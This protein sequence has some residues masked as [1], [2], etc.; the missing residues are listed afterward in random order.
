M[1]ASCLVVALG[2]LAMAGCAA[3]PANRAVVPA[4]S[5][6]PVSSAPIVG[7]G[8]PSGS[9]PAVGAPTSGGNGAR[10]ESD[11]H[12][13]A[14]QTHRALG[15]VALS[16]GAEAAVVATITSFIM[17]H[18]NSLRGDGCDGKVCSAGGLAANETL[19][20]LQWWNAGAWTVAALGVGVGAIVLWTSPTDAALHAEVAVA[21]AGSG[22]G[23]LLRG[24]F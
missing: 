22:S 15:W 13:V 3:L 11:D 20:N 2:V 24:A 18:Q 23:L 12:R 8:A 9:E 6:A 7:A 21:P 14:R 10:Q 16:V 17:L 19:R 1:R 4:P 5:P